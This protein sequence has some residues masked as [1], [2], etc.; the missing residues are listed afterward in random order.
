MPRS[1]RL[2]QLFVVWQKS[3]KKTKT[4]QVY[5]FIGSDSRQKFLRLPECKFCLGKIYSEPRRIFSICRLAMVCK[6]VRGN[7]PSPRRGRW[8]LRTLRSKWRMRMLPRHKLTF[9]NIQSSWHAGHPYERAM[10][11]YRRDIQ[12]AL[13]FALRVSTPQYSVLLR[14]RWPRW[15]QKEMNNEYWIL[16]NE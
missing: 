10:T 5:R 3:Y 4:L 9:H 16:N 6:M 7:K 15:G 12:T 11:S 14:S 1:R 13:P 2:K 8:H